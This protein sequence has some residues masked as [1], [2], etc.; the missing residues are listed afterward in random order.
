MK[1]G[2]TL[3]KRDYRSLIYPVIVGHCLPMHSVHPH[4]H[5]QS[6]A[7][8]SFVPGLDAM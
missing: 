4:D 3:A 1:L 7:V 6:G 5:S 8:M 2:H